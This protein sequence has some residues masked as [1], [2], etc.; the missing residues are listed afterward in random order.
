MK[1]LLVT[2]DR[3]ME[4]KIKQLLKEYNIAVVKNGEEAILSNISDIDAIIY[5]ALAGGI[6]EEDINK[7]YDSGYKNIP[8]IILMDELFPIE[9]ENIKPKIKKI[10][11]REG[12]LDK[13]PKALQ[14]VLGA[15][16]EAEIKEEI[17]V[18]EK[19]AQKEEQISTETVQV[20]TETPSSE[21]EKKGIETTE[22][23]WK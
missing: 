19:P 10:L 21:E 15:K 17:A 1:I 14:E 2:F 3:E 20:A 13:L 18:A 11:A 5:D 16:G 8:Y 12:D 4:N 9:P 6:A 7:L 23:W 22:D